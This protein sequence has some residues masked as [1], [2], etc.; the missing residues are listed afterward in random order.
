MANQ[1]TY[2]DCRTNSQNSQIGQSFCRLPSIAGNTYVKMSATSSMTT[3]PCDFLL[4]LLYPIFPN[5]IPDL[6]VLGLAMMLR[7]VGEYV[8]TLVVDENL[9]S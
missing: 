2:C 8:H 3:Y 6:D 5:M 4:S 7:V 9:G 1:A